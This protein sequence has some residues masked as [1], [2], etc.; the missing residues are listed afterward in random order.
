MSCVLVAQ[1]VACLGENEAKVRDRH[2][3]F[4]WALPID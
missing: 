4:G 1:L 2:C 3:G